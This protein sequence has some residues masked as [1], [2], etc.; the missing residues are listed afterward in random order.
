MKSRFL[1]TFALLGAISTLSAPA[2]H[3]QR[4]GVNA[5]I[6]FPSSSKTKQAFGSRFTSFGPG[7]G[8][9][10]IFRRRVSP[11]LDFMREDKN[12]NDSTVVFAGAKVLMPFGGDVAPDTIGCVP[13]YGFGVNLTY[14]DIDAPTFGVN[15]SGFGVGASAIVGASF[16]PHFFV[17]GRYR[18]MTSAADFNF[19]G[20][21]IGA[22]IRF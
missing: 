18:A 6:Y 22:G 21:Q 9:K 7:L 14:A 5:G 4:L 1:F 16:G 12:G 10:Q 3:A 8:T 2:A 20:A 15:D 13:Y 19:S 11:D 17:E